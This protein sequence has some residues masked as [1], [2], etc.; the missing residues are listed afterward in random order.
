MRFGFDEESGAPVSAL[1]RDVGAGLSLQ[2]LDYSGKPTAYRGAPGSGVNRAVAGDR[3]LDFSSGAGQGTNGPV[4][5]VTNASLG[6]REVTNFT[7]TVW[8]KQHSRQPSNI[9][10]RPFLLGAADATSDTGGTN[11]IG[12]KFQTASMLHFQINKVTAEANF[13]WSLPTNTWVFLAMV[14]DGAHIFIY[15]GGEKSPVTLVSAKSAPG[16]KVSFGGRG[17]LF[18]G[19]RRDRARGFEGWVDDFRFYS[20]A[21]DPN[22]IERIRQEAAGVSPGGD[23]LAL[24]AAAQ[25]TQ[26]VSNAQWVVVTAPAL[27]EAVMPLIEHRRVEGMKVLAYRTTDVLNPEQIRRGD[28]APLKSRLQELFQARTGPNYLLL[29]GVDAASKNSKGEETVVPGLPGATARMA[30]QPTDYFYSF[31]DQEGRPTVAVGR[32]PARTDQELRGMVQ[33]TLGLERVPKNG[34][35]QGRLL[36]IQGNPGGGPIAEA[37][38]QQTTGPRLGRVHPSWNIRAISHNAGSPYFLPTAWLHDRT[39]EYLRE[40]DLFSVYLGHSDGRGL[41]SANTNFMTVRDWANLDLGQRKGVFF[42]CGCFGCQP[43][44]PQGE[45]YGIAAA[46]NPAGPAAVI[47]ASGESYAA[48]GLLAA[49]GLLRCCLEPP[50][51][52]RLA[53]YWL[54]IQTNLA[55]GEIDDLT[56]SLFDMSDGT[57]SKVP[58]SVQ[59]REHLEMWTLLGDPALALPVLSPAISLKVTDEI[60]PGKCVTVRGSLPQ[61]FSGA[62]IRVS[63]DRPVG[64]RPQDWEKLPASTAENRTERDRIS[65]ANHQ[66]VNDPVLASAET[67][68]EGTRFTC[69]LEIPGTLRLP[70]VILRVRAETAAASAQGVVRLPVS[71]H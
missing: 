64:V 69:K 43:D 24:N 4:A 7:A 10:P 65:A 3:A 42:S 55:V 15:Q 36:L 5:A 14:Y 62:K 32:F 35:W 58:L 20:G 21:G 26:A 27:M 6:F 18:I 47:G 22:S 1:S 44:G 52:P 31:P 41:W 45:S 71:G 56:F 40:G 2:T 66:R 16:E 8:L 70:M 28:A 13:V 51:P 39:S 68:S 57:A 46:R 49:D 48:P 53:D 60:V 19:N 34:A 11:T 61:Q 54:A 37:F 25:E 9:G 67:I 33:K 29:V 38:L 17:A 63:L 30:G 23:V 50:F 12:L 59:R